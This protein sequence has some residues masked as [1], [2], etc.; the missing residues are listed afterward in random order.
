MK[1]HTEEDVLLGACLGRPVGELDRLHLA[2]CSFCLGRVVDEV[3]SNPVLR[4]ALV[5]DD[6]GAYWAEVQ[7]V[8]DGLDE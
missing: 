2:G 6:E 1:K 7:R 5:A 8:L 4:G 3:A